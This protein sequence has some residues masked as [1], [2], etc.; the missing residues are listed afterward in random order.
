MS[1][2]PAAGEPAVTGQVIAPTTARYIRHSEGSAIELAPGGR[3]LLVWSRFSDVPGQRGGVD[4]PATLVQA[5]SDDGGRTWTAPREMPV[6][7][8]RINVMQAGL[9]RVDDRILCFFSVRDA[10]DP[11][12]TS[13]VAG[14]Y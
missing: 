1:I 10:K 6:G 5:F 7:S 13:T 12:V 11:L 14:R 4:N 2:L 8:G 3:I 9:L